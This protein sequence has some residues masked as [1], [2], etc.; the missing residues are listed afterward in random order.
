[1]SEILERIRNYNLSEFRT[2]KS[3]KDFENRARLEE[4]IDLGGFMDGKDIE[5]F[6][7]R[8]RARINKLEKVVIMFVNQYL[9]MIK[10]AGRNY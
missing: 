5:Q 10:N 1:M 4:L 6:G 2:K 7:R 8:L 9:E 3:L